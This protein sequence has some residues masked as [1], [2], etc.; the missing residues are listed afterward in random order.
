MR[1]DGKDDNSA[2]YLISSRSSSRIHDTI[3]SFVYRHKPL[4]KLSDEE[5]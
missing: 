2:S 4:G 5:E 3:P 1:S